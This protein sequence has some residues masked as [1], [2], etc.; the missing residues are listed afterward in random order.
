M[1]IRLQPA[2][3]VFSRE[4]DGELVL[5][6]LGRGEYFGLDEIGALLWAAVVDGRDV[7]TVAE[8]VTREFAVDA[9]TATADLEALVDVLVERGLLVR[10]GA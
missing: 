8:Q 9:A 4:F 6:D 5:L 1:T 10:D 2:P 7:A 3:S